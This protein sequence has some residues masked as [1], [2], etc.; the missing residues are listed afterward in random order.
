MVSAEYFWLQKF[1]ASQFK[2]KNIHGLNTR[3]STD[4]FCGIQSVN[5]ASKI[6]RI[7]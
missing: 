6:L 7:V 5:T 1:G 2:V 4:T 3:K